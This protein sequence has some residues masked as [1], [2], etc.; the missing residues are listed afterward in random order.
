MIAHFIETVLLPW[1]TSPSTCIPG[2]LADVHPELPCPPASDPAQRART[3]AMMRAFGT[4][5]P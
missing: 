4:R 2:Q 5:S 1:P 3:I